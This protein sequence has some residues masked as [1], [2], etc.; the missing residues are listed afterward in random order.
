[1]AGEKLQ[2]LAT[3]FER[4]LVMLASRGYRKTEK[5][6][7]F[8]GA[9]EATMML[10]ADRIFSGMGYHTWRE[11]EQYTNTKAKQRLDLWAESPAGNDVYMI[12][13]K[14]VWDSYDARLDRKQFWGKRVLLHDFE[15]LCNEPS[16]S[17]TQKIVVWVGY[18]PTD[19]VLVKGEASPMRLGDALAAVGKEFP[20]AALEGQTCIAFEHYCEC[21]KWKFGHLFCWLVS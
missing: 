19:E 11:Y 6:F 20:T 21:G 16:S 4:H 7:S 14:V 13:G 12:E 18:S 8:D 10:I 9:N 15:R 17:S 3:A 2:W 5:C 1:M